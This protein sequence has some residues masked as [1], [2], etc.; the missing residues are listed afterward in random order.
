MLLVGVGV[1]REVAVTGG[2]NGLVGTYEDIDDAWAY[3]ECSEK[4]GKLG[5]LLCTP[6]GS[7][8][9]VNPVPVILGW[10]IAG[11]AI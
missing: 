7:T 10:F 3:F 6:F 11:G 1:S 9:A 4:A 5:S 8:R 2:E